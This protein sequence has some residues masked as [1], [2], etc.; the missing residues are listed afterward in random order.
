[1]IYDKWLSGD[2]AWRIQ[3]ALPSGSTVLGV[4]LSSDKMNISI[5]FSNCMAHPVLI[6]LANIDVS[7]HSKTS[8]HTYLLLVLLPISNCSLCGIMMNNPV[9][10]LCYC[11]TPLASWIADTPKESLLSATSSKVS[12]VTTATFKQFGNSFRH[13]AHTGEST[14]AAISTTYAQHKPSDFKP[15]LKVIKPYRLNGAVEPFWKGWALS[16]PSEFLTPKPLHHF[17]CMFWDHDAKW[18][19]AA[20]RPAELD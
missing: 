16:G 11:F 5:M 17:H 3:D 19:I 8:L 2:R 1:C 18:C 7:I 14:L 10:N 9:S 15:F 6:S 4:V 13:P 12:P 20:V